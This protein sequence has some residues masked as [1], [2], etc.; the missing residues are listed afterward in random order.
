MVMAQVADHRACPLP[1][2]GL[3]LLTPVQ[4]AAPV[5]RVLLARRGAVNMAAVALPL[6]RATLAKGEAVV[7][8]AVALPSAWAVLAM[9]RVT[10]TPAT[11]AVPVAPVTDAS[12]GWV[13]MSALAVPPARAALASTA[14]AMTGIEFMEKP[15]H[16]QI[17]LLK[18][19]TMGFIRDGYKNVPAEMTLSI[20]ID[21]S[22]RKNGS[23]NKD[24]A[25]IALEAATESGMTK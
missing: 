14:F 19:I 21:A 3:V 2:I 11:D 25:D 12:V 1:K 6:A 18:P 24:L 10:C 8:A 16:E 9:G 13:V 23:G 5:A 4:T 17:S 7:M 22:I 20:K 15:A